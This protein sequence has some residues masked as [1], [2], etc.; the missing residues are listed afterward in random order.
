MNERAFIGLGANLGDRERNIERAIEGVSETPGIE[1]VARA[2]LYETEPVGPVRQPWFLNTVVEVHTALPP[3]ELLDGLKA[4]EQEL[5]RTPRER[6]GPRRI[7]LD[8]LLY[9]DRAID[10]PDLVIP[11]PELHRRRFVLVP[12]VELAPRLVHPVLGQTMEVLLRQFEDE[13]N[14]QKGVRPLQDDQDGTSRT[15][16]FSSKAAPR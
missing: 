8:L 6:W 15:R 9:G 2:S 12:L 1:V 14:D 7:D 11:H 10:E 3:R 16:R 4:I 5:G 13:R